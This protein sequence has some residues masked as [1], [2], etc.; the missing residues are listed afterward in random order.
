MNRIVNK[1]EEEKLIYNAVFVSRSIR[2]VLKML[3]LAYAGG[4][5]T[6]IKK[7]IDKYGIDCSHFKGKRWSRGE[8]VARKWTLEKFN[9]HIL[10]YDG[11]KM[12][13]VK[14]KEKIL[15]F[16]LLANKCDICGIEPFWNNKKLVLQIDHVNGNGVDNRLCNLRIVCPNCHSQTPTFCGRKLKKHKEKDVNGKSQRVFVVDKELNKLSNLNFKHRVSMGIPRVNTRKVERPPLVDVV[17]YVKENGYC[18]AG[19]K[20]GVSDNMIR[21]WIRKGI[22]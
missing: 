8:K 14:I 1:E 4:S 17:E 12:N 22:Q 16:G 5:H 21:K 18:A 10:V 9:N 6:R 7:Q 2:G 13:R 11:I 20:Y 19:R 3:G 15:E